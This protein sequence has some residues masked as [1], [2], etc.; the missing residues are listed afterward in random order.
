MN[1]K[2]WT[3]LKKPV[4]YSTA[5]RRDYLSDKRREERRKKEEENMCGKGELHSYGKLK[6]E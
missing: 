6:G 3:G 4:I 1:T 5:K 2:E